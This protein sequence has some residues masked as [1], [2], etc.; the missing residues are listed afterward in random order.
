MAEDPV[1]AVARLSELTLSLN[2]AALPL[3]DAVKQLD[4]HAARKQERESGGG[5]SG[6]GMGG[7]AR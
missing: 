3:L 6:L 2:E 1:H 5:R 7:M 4:L